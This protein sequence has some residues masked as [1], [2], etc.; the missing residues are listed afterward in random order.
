VTLIAAF[1]CKEGVVLCADSQETIDIPERGSYR[2][3]VNKLEQRDTGKYEV[4]VGGA[5]DG[6]LVDGF[7]DQF[8]E[9]VSRWRNEYR[10][11]KVL[12][13]IRRFVRDYHATD[14]ALSPAHPDDKHLGFIVCLR[15]K[16][17]GNI[18]LW[19][20]IEL[21]VH[22]ISDLSLLGWEEALYWREAKRLYSLNGAITET[23]ASSEAILLGVHLFLIAK[24]T[25]NVISGDTKITVVRNG[26]IH[27]LNPNDVKEL[28]TR[29]KAFDYLSAVIFLAL[30]DVTITR[31]ELTGW[32]KD[33]EKTVLQLHDHFTLH[34]AQT[35]LERLRALPGYPHIEN[36]PE[37]PY[38]QLPTLEQTIEEMRSDENII[39]I[40]ERVKAQKR[41]ANAEV[42]WEQFVDANGH[43]LLLGLRKAV[44]TLNRLSQL[45][46]AF[47][48]S[49][50]YGQIESEETVAIKHDIAKR[51]DAAREELKALLPP[52]NEE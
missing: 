9:T 26:G 41:Q 52:E 16:D 22:S 5:G 4:I 11:S 42:G 8:F 44:R 32:L 18:S 46:R 23:P 47:F 45:N 19:K 10:E 14:I 7:V 49:G 30:P 25:S 43:L 27:T 1:R 40:R 24:D 2:V 29:V 6:A 50:R 3:N 39:A 51:V 31:T 17:T 12:S 34:I 33:F 28:E 21:H 20:I 13:A 36:F 35:M 38:L 37:D 48:Q 15:G